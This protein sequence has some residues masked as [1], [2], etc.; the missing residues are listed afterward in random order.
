MLLRQKTER[1]FPLFSRR[2]SKRAEQCIANRRE[3]LTVRT[4]LTHRT[5]THTH[6]HTH[7]QSQQQH[8]ESTSTTT[9]TTTN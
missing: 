2:R 6:T 4:Q 3:Q 9:T 7:T 8:Q 5:H 1:R